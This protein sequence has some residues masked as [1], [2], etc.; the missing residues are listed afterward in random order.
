[1]ADLNDKEKVAEPKTEEEKV[2]AKLQDI[3]RSRTLR[4]EMEKKYRW[5]E[6]IREYRGQFSLADGRYDLTI[7]PINLIFAYVK[8]ELPSLYIRDPHI[9]VNPKNKTSIATAKVLEEVINYIWRYKKIKREIKKCIVD[10]LLIGHSWIKLGY[11]GKFGTVED[12]MG[13]YTEAVEEEDIFAYYVNWED[14]TFSPDA[15]DPPY[16]C[17]WISHSVWLDIDEVKKNPRYQN[18]HLLQESYEDRE[19]DY[20]GEEIDGDKAKK[21]KVR[22]EEVWDLENKVVCTLADGVDKYIEPPK[23]WPL[24]MR[25]FPFAMLK[26]NASNNLAYGISDVAMFEPQVIELIKVR[27]MSLDHL[28]RYNRQLLTSPGN[29]SD[30][31][32]QKL[33][34][35]ITGSVIECEDVD[36]VKPLPYP[37]LQ[38]DIYAIE[39]RIK[40]DT[41][42]I[43]GQS[44]Q[45]RGATQKTST[46]SLGELQQMREGSVNRR[47]E[48][49]DMVEDFVEEIAGKLSALLKQFVTSP[50]YIRIL[51]Q[52]SPLLQQAI[53]ERATAQSEQG[54]TNQEGF[55]FTAEDIEGEFDQEVVSGSST[56]LDRVEL[57]KTLFQMVELGPKAGAVPGGPFMGTVAKLI[58]E[59]IDVEE[60][61]AALDMEQKAQQQQ[62][63]EQAQKTEEMRTLALSQ[64]AAETQMDA[65]NAATKQNKVLVDFMRLMQET[66]VDKQKNMIELLKAKQQ[67]RKKD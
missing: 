56:P 45:E 9:K 54:I 50:Y 2:R 32:M 49:V 62:K 12:D 3:K 51:G 26:F 61:I 41:I 28:K 8:T 60:L 18:T 7:I 21:G 52:Q 10:T 22:L 39:E 67:N 57:L 13:S 55:T 31:E 66:D 35:A 43:S 25:G 14:I 38:S 36:K 40:E 6:L 5:K 46:R 23:Q 33:S 64:Q 58:A 4:D 65:E 29:I 44:P 59:N 16:D 19:L 30:D 34:K 37:P 24:Q 20:A 17:K 11:T 15:I 1:M 47:S 53:S 42:N 27:S 48:K 63:Q